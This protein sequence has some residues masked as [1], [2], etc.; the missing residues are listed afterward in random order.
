MGWIMPYHLATADQL[1]IHGP[2]AERPGVAAR[3]IALLR[4]L[5]LE[6]DSA[7]EAAQERV[8]LIAGEIFTLSEEIIA[9]N[10]EIIDH[11]AI[12]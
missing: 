10:P 12:Q 9:R 2:E 3:Q 4:A 6:T 7:R 1:L 5:G 11:G 8:Q